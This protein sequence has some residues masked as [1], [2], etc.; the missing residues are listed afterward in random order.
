MKR[1]LVVVAA[2]VGFATAASAIGTFSV[3]STDTSNSAKST[4]LVGETIVLRFEGN[5]NGGLAAGIFGAISY[6]GAI[7]DFVSNSQ[8][9]MFNTVAGLLNSDDGTTGV[10]YM[11]NQLN[12]AGTPV[13]PLTQQ[14]IALTTLTA[15]AEGVSQVHL[16]ADVFDF[17]GDYRQNPTDLVASFTV[18][19][20]PE[21]ATAA[22]I[23]LGLI[24]LL[25]GGRRRA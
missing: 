16:A 3:I 25:L 19:A 15:T 12:S 11:F 20:I 8:T 18:V 9:P 1:T 7:T 23:G 5:A 17:F 4:F 10:S 21:P 14:Q 6:S 13:D 24:G 2:V 22:L